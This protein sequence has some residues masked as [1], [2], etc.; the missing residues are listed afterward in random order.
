MDTINS[1]IGRF[2][3]ADDHKDVSG[4]RTLMVLLTIVSGMFVFVPYM[5]CCKT[6]SSTVGTSSATTSDAPKVGKLFMITNC[7]AAGMLI[8][9]A[10]CHILPTCDV[11][12]TNW[13][14][15]QAAIE[16]AEAVA[17]GIDPHA[18]HDH[19]LLVED[20]HAGETAEEHAAHSKNK[21]EGTAMAPDVHVEGFPMPYVVLYAGFMLM[22]F[23]D[24]VI[25]KP[26]MKTAS[27]EHA[28]VGNHSVR[29]EPVESAE[30][31]KDKEVKMEVNINEG[32]NDAMVNEGGSGGNQAENYE[33]GGHDHGNYEQRVGMAALSY[34]GISMLLHSV[35]DGFF[36]GV[37]KDSD[38]MN[39]L[40]TS[41]VIHKIPLAIAFGTAFRAANKS[42]A[43][44]LWVLIMFVV[45]IIATPMGL[46]AGMNLKISDKSIP[47][48][49]L[50]ALSAGTFVYIG[51]CDLLVH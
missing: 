31:D 28:A 20:S 48:V 15:N 21:T 29:E 12:Y 37:F 32:E 27:H 30:A 22:L 36:H 2:L 8:C 6:K 9:L 41:L 4:V 7:F 5:S 23:M 10:Y 47:M 14:A 49:V 19:R 26:A 39:V 16:T 25:F 3:A 51:A 46:F 43:N 17:A 1:N 50:Q 40:L 11:H 35:I 13:L 24:Q 33:G 18:G 45:Y 34:F 42:P 44:D 38:S